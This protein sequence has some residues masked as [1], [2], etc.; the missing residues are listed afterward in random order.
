[1]LF[2]LAVYRRG[3]LA[4]AVVAHVTANTLVAVTVLLTGNWG[5]WA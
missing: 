3:R 2:A 1:M 4:D 5:L